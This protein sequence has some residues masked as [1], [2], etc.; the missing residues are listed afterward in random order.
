MHASQMLVEIFL[1][2]KSFTR[3]SLAVRVRT[4]QLFARTTVFIV[5]FTFVSEE[6]TRIRE[7]G[8]LF[9]TFGRTFVRSIMLVHMFA[10]EFVSQL[11]M[12]IIAGKEN[13]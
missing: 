5:N 7:T 13:N 4:V 8:K 1:S 9:A 10:A 11:S 6:T 2:R 12:L 3:V